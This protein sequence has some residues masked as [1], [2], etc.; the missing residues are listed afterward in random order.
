M[1][2]DAFGEH[3]ARHNL[4]ALA[5]AVDRTPTERLDRYLD[6]LA[7]S[8]PR[9]SSYLRAVFAADLAARPTGR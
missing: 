3:L 2:F 6:F 8:M 1:H 9:T 4:A 7:A 5:R